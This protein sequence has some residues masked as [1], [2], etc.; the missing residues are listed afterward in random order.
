MN[1]KM[2]FVRIHWRHSVSGATGKGSSM[3]ENTANERIVRLRKLNPKME[4]WIEEVEDETD[5]A[6]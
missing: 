1:K 6:E 5:N 2:K 3:S 4:Y